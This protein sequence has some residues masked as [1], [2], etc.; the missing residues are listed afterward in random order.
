[1]EEKTKINSDKNNHI[2]PKK[3][4]QNPFKKDLIYKSNKRK[5][6]KI[7]KINKDNL[8]MN[9]TTIKKISKKS[10]EKSIISQSLKKVLSTKYFNGTIM[11][12]NKT[13]LINKNDRKCENIN[14]KKSS[15]AIKQLTEIKNYGDNTQEI[16]SIFDIIKRKNIFGNSS[17]KNFRNKNHKSI[18]N[19]N[20]TESTLNLL[21]IQKFR[22]FKRPKMQSDLSTTFK[23][24][25][26][27]LNYSN[28]ATKSKRYL[29]EK[30][31]QK[32]KKYFRNFKN[33]LKKND[34]IYKSEANILSNR[35]KNKNESKNNKKPDNSNPNIIS[36]KISKKSTKKIFQSEKKNTEDIIKS[37]N[38]TIIANTKSANTKP[39]NISSFAISEKKVEHNNDNDNKMMGKSPLKSTYFKEHMKFIDANTNQVQ[40]FVLDNNYN[41]TKESDSKFLN[42]ELGQTNGL[43]FTDSIFYSMENSYKNDKNKNKII[44]C[45]HSVEYMEKKA[46]EFLSSIKNLPVFQKD[47]SKDSYCDMTDNNLSSLDEF[48]NGEDINRI[49]NLQINLKK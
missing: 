18:K 12:L 17:N 28:K 4:Y 44:E 36:Y 39:T 5:T 11:N 29:Q 42:Y 27:N 47:K 48:K 14:F 20:N 13:Q 16:E 45:E 7:S 1:M 3:I 26:L 33:N 35:T 25:D 34:I 38:Y 30:T 23:K 37:F 6:K 10:T 43:S 21:N 46:N 31:S 2:I 8:L 24:I 19:N 49:I 15:G 22:Y 9:S 32:Y 41:K 40:I